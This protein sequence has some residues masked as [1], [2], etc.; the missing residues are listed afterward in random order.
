MAVSA[1]DAYLELR[2]R[3]GGMIAGLKAARGSVVS[4]VGEMQR[5]WGGGTGKMVDISRRDLSL[6][7]SQFG[8]AGGTIGRVFYSIIS[9]GSISAAE[10]LKTFSGALTAVGVAIAG[11][12][13][14]R[15][16]KNQ[17][18]EL[19]HSIFGGLTALQKYQEEI[20]EIQ[21]ATAKQNKETDK[22]SAQD[23]ERESFAKRM[24]ELHGEDVR[25]Q[26]LIRKY[27]KELAE[28]EK[29][30][31]PEGE[32]Y[33]TAEASKI[34]LE[35]AQKEKQIQEGVSKR[36][37]ELRDADY[38]RLVKQQ[39]DEEKEIERRAE[40]IRAFNERQYQEDLNRQNREV[41]EMNKRWADG[42][43]K[44]EQ[45]EEKAQRKREEREIGGVRAQI[46]LMQE[47]RE[48]IEVFRPQWVG[49]EELWKQA[50][51]A[52]G[53]TG[54]SEREKLDKVITELRKQVKLL[55]EA[56]RE[57]REGD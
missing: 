18:D 9:Q 47:Q 35:R 5:T 39:Q 54:E 34:L 24:I 46:E 51:V 31:T 37:E 52:G 23:K 1:G 28:F 49:A 10:G 6:I 25:S 32:R 13:A 26:E 27:R 50:M 22:M 36:I 45:D 8:Q 57:R 29:Q 7:T 53:I 11:F 20:E 19:Y 41:L 14:G 44:K 56:A 4:S 15:Q 2:V 33:T 55:E 21:E 16:L 38:D 42:L 12:S 48:A 17:F 43:R 40:I 30:E 3:D